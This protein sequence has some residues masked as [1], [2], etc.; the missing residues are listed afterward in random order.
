MSK[1]AS[2]GLGHLWEELKRRRVIRVTVLYAIAG[3]IVIEVSST[4]LPNLNLPQW[5][6][7]LVTV[8]VVLGFVLAVVLAW[9]FDIGPRGCAPDTAPASRGGERERRT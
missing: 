7:T 1:E 9:A 6:V 4:V 5:S 3:W 8:L 2:K